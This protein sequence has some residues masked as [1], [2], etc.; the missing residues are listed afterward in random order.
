M[1]EICGYIGTEPIKDKI[2]IDAMSKHKKNSDNDRVKTYIYGNVAISYFKFGIRGPGYQNQS[3]SKQYENEK[4]TIV[5]NGELY[6]ITEIK[7]ILEQEGYSFETTCDTEIVLVAYIHFKEK[8]LE[9]FDGVFA[10]SILEENNNKMFLARDRLG[11]KNLFYYFKNSNFIFAS[12]IKSILKHPEVKAVIG[13]QEVCEIFGLGPARSPGKTYFRDIKEI[14]PGYYGIYSENEFNIF[15]YWDLETNAVKDDNISEIINKVKHLVTN[16]LKRQLVADVPVCTMLSGGLDSSILTYL[17]KE[18][19]Q[20]LN[21][22]SIDFKNNHKNFK[23][24]EYQPTSDEDYIKVMVNLLKTNHKNIYFNNEDLFKSLKEAMIARDMPGMADIDCS[25]LEFC[26]KIKESGY[27]MT[28]SGECADE[29]FGGYPWYYKPTLLYSNTFPWARS[30][31]DARLKIINEKIISKSE[32]NAYVEKAYNDTVKNVIYESPDVMENKFRKT[33]YLTV[34]WFMA[35]LVERADRMSAQA[36]LTVRMPFAD[37]KIF[38][39]LYNIKAKYKLGLIDKNTEPIEKYILRKAFENELPK[40]IV[41]RK[42]SPFPKTH[43]PVYLDKIETEVKRIINSSN[44]PVLQLI[45]IR[46][47]YEILDNH[48]KDL[49]ENWFGQ[50]M[51]YPQMLAYLIQINMWLEEYNIE[52]DI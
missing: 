38:E 45:N 8:C 35:T 26:K 30:L 25:M 44:A 43:D 5:Y 50:L 21:T 39:Y 23:E 24:N 16:S 51:T 18:Q 11:I 4:Y 13:K 41:Y 7:T 40:E 49:K 20:D 14:L 3:M 29:I 12:E 48:G 9:L 36:G 52:I 31:I 19:V 28:I 42:K 34:K 17:A 27:N 6:N 1:C 15:K 37:Y 33:C 47:I 46:F 2:I 22:F 32:L 10:F